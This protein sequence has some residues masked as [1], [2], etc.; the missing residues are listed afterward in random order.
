MQTLRHIK[1]VEW[2][3][4]YRMQD[5]LLLD[6]ILADEFQSIDA[7]GEVSNKKLELEYIKNNKPTYSSFNYK[8]TRLE[9]F[10]NNTAII[11][12]TGTL[13]G[14]NE[15]G[16]Y[17]MTYQSSNVFIKRKNHWKAISSHVSGIKKG[18]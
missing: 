16:D 7:A 3:A 1:E 18:F 13:K 4:S 5:T 8:I 6:K 17:V 14:S 15:K 2:P 10:E 9:I 12:G 11:S